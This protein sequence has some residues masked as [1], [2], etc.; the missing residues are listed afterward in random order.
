M[1]DTHTDRQTHTITLLRGKDTVKYQVRTSLILDQNIENK[2][3]LKSKAPPK[4]DIASKKSRNSYS[5]DGFLP[6]IVYKQ[7]DN[8][9]LR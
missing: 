1:T 4:F 5:F 2:T 8:F 3:S 9:L 6:I 7:K